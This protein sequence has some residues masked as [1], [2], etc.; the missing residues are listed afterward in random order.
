[1]T[2]N[3]VTKISFQ[4]VLKAPVDLQ[5]FSHLCRKNDAF[6]EESHQRNSGLPREFSYSPRD[7]LS[8]AGHLYILQTARRYVLPAALSPHGA[9]RR[10]RLLSA[11]SGHCSVTEV[12]MPGNFLRDLALLT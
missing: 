4:S 9:A 12:T 6:V 3:V 2:L 8:A 7:S 1:M 10:C 5:W 11:A